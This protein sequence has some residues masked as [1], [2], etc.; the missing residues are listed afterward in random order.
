VF[1]QAVLSS[2]LTE[3][4]PG[5]VTLP[6]EALSVSAVTTWA[7][8]AD[9]SAASTSAAAPATCGAAIEVPLMI[10]VPVSEL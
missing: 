7:G 2:L 9:G 1:S 10:W 8:V 6:A 3:P 5:E 4:V